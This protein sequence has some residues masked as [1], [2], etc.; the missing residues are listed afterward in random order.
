MK[1]DDLMQEKRYVNGTKIED[2]T[3]LR[4]GGLL[5]IGFDWNRRNA[6]VKT[7]GTKPPIFWICSCNCGKTK[8]ISGDRLKQ[9]KAKSCG[10]CYSF[11]DILA[12][13]CGED[14]VS[15]YW[16]AKN[17]ISPF[18]ISKCSSRYVWIKCD[19]SNGHEDYRVRAYNFTNGYRCPYCAGKKVD[20]FNSFGYKN[21]HLVKNWGDKNKITPFEVTNGSSKKVW[22][23]CDDCGHERKIRV[24]NVSAHGYTCTNCG[25]NLSYPNK[26]IYALMKQLN[27]DFIPEMKFSWSNGK[28]YDVYVP[29][30]NCIIENHGRQ[31]Y[32]ETWMGKPLKEEKENDILKARLAKENGIAHYIVLDCRES[33]KEWI[34]HSV[35]NCE[36]PSLMGFSESDIDWDECDRF[37]L[38]N[39]CKSVCELWNSGHSVLKIAN[40]VKC[41]RSRVSRLLNKGTV[42][43]W[44]QYDGAKQHNTSKRVKVEG[45]LNGVSIGVFDSIKEAVSEI[46]ERYNVK[47]HGTSVS[48]VCRGK[49]TNTKGFFFKY[50]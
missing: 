18:E 16:S 9:G 22:F 29:S 36:L 44:C 19:N 46:Y 40:E 7:S 32:D 28:V 15:K 37:T 14:N 26:F 2:L 1:E 21:S 10:E 41:S 30:I 3:G 39:I 33:K 48:A 27:V 4:F 13:T 38:T 47:I 23:K 11:G 34:K 5:V 49:A 50:V 35:M 24:Y 43:G 8:S 45:F 20:Y 42:L 25:D 17:N 31:H 6:Y 12:S